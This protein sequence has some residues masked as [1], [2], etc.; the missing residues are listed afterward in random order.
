M[1]PITKSSERKSVLQSLASVSFV[2]LF[3]YLGFYFIL[4]MRYLWPNMTFTHYFYGIIMLLIGAK[5]SA[6]FF[7]PD[8]SLSPEDIELTEQMNALGL[9]LS[10]HTNKEVLLYTTSVYYLPNMLKLLYSRSIHSIN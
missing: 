1:M 7:W 3:V 10:F 2:N 5:G 4:V 8:I 9:P 6:R